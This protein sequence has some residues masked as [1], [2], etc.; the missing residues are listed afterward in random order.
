MRERIVA[1]AKSILVR[2]GLTG[3]TVDAVAREAGCAK[4]LIHYHHQSKSSLL[5]RLA[6][7]L[8]ADRVGR[9]LEAFDR[10]GAPSLDALWM[11]L[12]G[13]A[14]S[15]EAAAWLALV[16]LADPLV[17]AELPP[18]SAELQALAESVGAAL[19]LPRVSL[20]T[21]RI[22]LA[23]MDGIQVPLLLG[24]APEA[25]REAYDRIWLAALATD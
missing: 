5:A 21:I 11:V 12:Q 1:A 20:G 8:R 15:G 22:A 18:R 4:G 16:A 6:A 25:V 24:E 2:D 17:R 7:S 14:A 13:E 10:L 3:W 23:A 9:R 19:D